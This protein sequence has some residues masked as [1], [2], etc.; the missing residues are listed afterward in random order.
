MKP[1]PAT[2]QL[3]LTN[4]PR[5]YAPPLSD[6]AAW[7]VEIV[8]DHPPTLRCIKCPRYWRPTWQGEDGDIHM[9]RWWLCPRGCNAALA[10]VYPSEAEAMDRAYP[11]VPPL[12]T[13]EAGCRTEIPTAV[14]TMDNAPSDA[15]PGVASRTPTGR[16]VEIATRWRERGETAGQ[17]G[18]ALRMK[19]KTVS[20]QITLLRRV[21]GKR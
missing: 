14:P 15:G 8:S 6:L 11:W 19:A 1:T 21:Y 3:S 20:N 5:S 9:G 17:I 13:T 7:G 2:P 10:T 18:V 12:E 4:P 16:D